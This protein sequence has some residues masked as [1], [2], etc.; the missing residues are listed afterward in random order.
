MSS[1]LQNKQNA[2]VASEV[3]GN[4]LAWCQSD[5]VAISVPVDKVSV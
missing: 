4:A 1:C 2:T 5:L 3:P